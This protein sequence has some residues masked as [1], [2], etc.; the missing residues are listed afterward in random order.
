MTLPRGKVLKAK[1]ALGPRG[2][3][4]SEPPTGGTPLGSGKVGRLLKAAAADASVQATAIVAA[5]EEKARAILAGAEAR[6]R[7]IGDEAREEGRTAG[8]AELAA[9]WV[10]LR[11]EQE[12]RDERE[13][14]RTTELARFM[15]ER[16]IGASL[17]LEPAQIQSIAR[18]ALATA[19]Q[20]RRIAVR[21]HP[22]D[23][24]ALRRDLAS[25]GL[26]QAAIEIHADPSRTRGS[27]LFDTDLGTLDANLTLQLDRLARSLRDSFRS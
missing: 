22:D 5:A 10:K 27:L 12:S 15:A 17:A 1:S 7:V 9:A 21:A 11:A 25:L 26:E 23:A 18:Q 2:A 20:S 24:A 19:R 3:V 16:L 13:L 4:T 14:D 6:A 8:L